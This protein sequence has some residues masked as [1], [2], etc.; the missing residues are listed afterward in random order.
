MWSKRYNWVPTD[1]E[2]DMNGAGS[3]AA[4]QDA[5]A[6]ELDQLPDLHPRSARGLRP[7]AALGNTGW[8]YDD[9]P[10]YFIKSEG[11]ARGAS[12]FHMAPDCACRTWRKHELIEAFIDGAGGSACWRTDDF[13]GAQRRA[14]YFQLNT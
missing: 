13:N 2:P 5:S 11:N 4:R 14:G 9:V 12:A 10:P 8:G 1:P 7:W 3:L 6:L